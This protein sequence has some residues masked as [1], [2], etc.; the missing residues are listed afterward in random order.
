MQHYEEINREILFFSNL[1]QRFH[2]LLRADILLAF[3]MQ[4]TTNKLPW[5]TM[6]DFNSS[7]RYRK[8]NVEII[9]FLFLFFMPFHCGRKNIYGKKK[10]KTFFAFGISFCAGKY[11]YFFLYNNSCSVSKKNS[12]VLFLHRGEIQKMELHNLLYFLIKI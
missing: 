10:K 4:K 6:T 11:K 12:Y 1:S 7:Y 5:I 8:F 3:F 2:M 9:F